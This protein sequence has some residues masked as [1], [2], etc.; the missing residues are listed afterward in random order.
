MVNIPDIRAH[1]IFICGHPKAGTSLVLSILDAHPQLVV[2]PEESVFFRKFLPRAQHLSLDEQLKLARQQLIHFFTWNSQNP[3]PS[4]A[5]YPDRDYSRLSFDKI[6]HQMDLLAREKADH[7]GDVLSAAVLA[8]G[9]V[10]GSLSEATRHWVEK[11]PYNEF[12][13]AQIYS[14]WPEARCVHVLRDPRDNF[15]SYRQKHPSWQP[16]F[17]AKNWLRSTRAGFVNQTTYGKQRYLILRYED[18]VLEPMETLKR[19]VEFLDIDWQPSLTSP[20][21]AGEIWKG[22]SMFMQEFNQISAAPI[23]RWKNH[24]NPQD[25][26][27]IEW[28]SRNW[29]KKLAYP[30]ENLSATNP[31]LVSV[32][33]WRVM[34]WPLRARLHRFAKR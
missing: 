28:F 14:W 10:S 2:Y 31:R 18:L 20:T 13:T 8:Y 16:E 19:L 33:L 26:A 7:P 9:K 15:V 1:P 34:T 21:R 29:M 22:N 6:A 25:A 12:F 23:G 4:Q 3:P 11:S 5:G 30:L 27:V 24:L 17:F 32:T